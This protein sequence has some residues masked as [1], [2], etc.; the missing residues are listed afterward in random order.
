MKPMKG[1]KKKFIIVNFMVFL[2]FVVKMFPGLL[3]NV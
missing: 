2:F 3:G 1:M